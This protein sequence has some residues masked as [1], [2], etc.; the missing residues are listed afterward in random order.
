MKLSDNYLKLVEWSK[1][2]QCYVG[3]C[4][5][6]MFGGIHG[7]DEAKV[8]QELCEVVNEW[9]SHLEKNGEP[10]PAATAGRDYSG[11]FM[12][13]VGKSLH[14]ALVVDALRNNESLNSLCVRLLK[15]SSRKS[16]RRR[17]SGQ[18]RA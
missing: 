3:S 15:T 8:F 14:K 12:I 13:R 10:L 17:V 16:T 5:S 2:D 1:E 18:H 9:I 4:P 7:N 6:L 11:K